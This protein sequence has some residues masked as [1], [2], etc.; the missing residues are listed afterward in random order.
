MIYLS[1]YITFLWQDL[2]NE[3]YKIMTDEFK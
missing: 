2:G 1:T 3:I